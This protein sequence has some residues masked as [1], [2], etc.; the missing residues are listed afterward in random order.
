MTS[1][2]C[3]GAQPLRTVR[4]VVLGIALAAGGCASQS[5]KA[6][7]TGARAEPLA[8]AVKFIARVGS[9]PFR[10]GMSYGGIGRTASRIT[11]TD[12]RLY[13]SSVALIDAQGH[14]VPVQLD[15]DDRW[16]YRDVTLLDFEDGTGPCRN[17][18][19]GMNSFVRG[20]V[21][22]SDYRGIQFVLGVP[23]DLNHRDPTLAPAPL[24]LTA[25]SWSWQYGYKFVKIDMA[26]RGQP[27]AGSAAPASSR[28]A[29]FPIH[30]GSTECA[31]A[32]ATT[33]PSSCARPNRVT[34]RFD[35][36]DPAHEQIRIDL[37][38][39]LHDTDVDTNAPNSAPGC[40][41]GPDDEDCRYVMHAFG[42]PFDGGTAPEQRMFSVDRKE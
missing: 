27:R 8:V 6:P 26:T 40:M 4:T 31:S 32:S 34:V 17:G 18:T 20:R 21:P 19:P 24:N 23:E 5:I 7:A 42:L 11:P 3:K 35:Q 10:C 29:G 1:L 9:Q 36:F 28:A 16:Q 15:Q 41:S 22:A 12:F 39:L 14:V 25:M 37:A 33:A 30:L 38:A 13:V 2:L